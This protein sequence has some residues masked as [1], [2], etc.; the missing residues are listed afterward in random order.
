MDTEMSESAHNTGHEQRDVTARLIAWAGVGL[1]VLALFTFVAMAGVLGLLGERE[2]RLSPPAS[3]LAADY[4]LQIPPEPR[5]Q[6]NP[7]ADL[8][9][10][11]AEEDFLLHGYAWV[12]R[13]T[14]TVR[15]P[16][17]RAIELLAETQAASHG[18]NHQ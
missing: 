12:D 4:G 7:V 2:A 14:G 11:R 13:D 16:I 18:A 10:L 9:A 1:L 5:L 15:I 17:E 3:P 8:E 6:D